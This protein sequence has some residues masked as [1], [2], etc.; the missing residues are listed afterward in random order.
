MLTSSEIDHFV[1]QGYVPLREAFPPA[2]AAACC[3]L[4]RQQ[5][6]LPADPPW[7]G[8]V[9]RGHVAGQST[10][11][12]ATSPRFVDAIGQL[13]DGESWTPRHELGNWVIRYPSTDAVDDPH[14]SG[15]HIDASFPGNDPGNDPGDFAA[16]R[17][18][19]RSRGRGLLLLCLLSNVRDD[20][21][22]TRLRPGSHRALPALLAPFGDDGVPGI[23]A[24]LPPVEGPVV[25]A[26]GEAGDVYLCHPF[27][28]HA[29]T[30][31]HRGS[32]PRYVSQPGITVEDG[33]KGTGP[34]KLGGGR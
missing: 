3:D 26:T 31:P 32:E 2:V 18:N 7:P 5:L 15:W 13:L 22:P 17:V 24:P 27:M 34:T 28:V 1:E 29:A 6:G 25:N 12:A 19:H 33:L 11:Q 4:A 14:D 10:Y 20:D 23:D 16:W 9:V 8:A 21:A 30:W